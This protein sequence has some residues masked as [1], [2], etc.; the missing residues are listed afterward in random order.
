ME[1]LRVA[2][3]FCHLLGFSVALYLVMREDLRF[4][5]TSRFDLGELAVTA[6]DVSRA[7]AL[8]LV[9][10]AAVI[11]LDTGFQ[12]EEIAARPK[13]VAKIIVVSV[14]TVNGALLH[15]VL[16]PMLAGP[17]ARTRPAAILASVLGAVSS[18]SWLYASFLGVANP[19]AGQLG[20]NGFLGL[21]ASAVA[22][23]IVVSLAV[24]APRFQRLVAG[25]DARFASPA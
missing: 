22:G 17:A 4:L 7:L 15:L 25:T 11:W 5:L 14:L 12:L 23:G 6:R 13:L 9:S 16:F 2:L 1:V 3:I 20:L 24:V 19:L 8:L 21:Y 10:G 18:V